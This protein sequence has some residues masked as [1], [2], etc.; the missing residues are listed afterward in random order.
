MHFREYQLKAQETDQT[1]EADAKGMLVPLL[2]L[3]GEVGLLLVEY[4][5]HL[6]DGPAH[7]LFRE[8]IAE[9]L[10][11]LL[12]YAANVATKFGLDLDE[13]ATQNLAKTRDRW[14][15]GESQGAKVFDEGYASQERLPRQFEVELRQ[16]VDGDKVEVE[17]WWGG[18]M[19]GSTL[20]DNAYQDD[21]Y[22]S[23]DVFHLTFAAV[24]GWSPIARS[25]LGRKRRSNPKVD[26]VEDGGRARVIE[27]ASLPWSSTMPASTTTWPT[28]R[29]STTPS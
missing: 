26:E 10:G 5:K 17:C 16:V 2:G 28:C 25:F 6:R 19:V 13:V 7:R 11:D 8:Q 15:A 21:G 4:K 14:P 1:P 20:T 24:L 12:W 23:H 22:R 3:A 27:S 18:R 9:D 29:R